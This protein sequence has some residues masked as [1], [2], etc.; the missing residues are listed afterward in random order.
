MQQVKH[1]NIKI[2]KKERKRRRGGKGRGGGGGGKK[3]EK[4]GK[5]GEGKKEKEEGGR[6]ERRG[7]T[8][9]RAGAPPFISKKPLVGSPSL[10]ISAPYVSGFFNINTEVKPNSESGLICV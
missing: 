8:E 4:K 7:E 6:G 2:W 1:K 3:G 9:R 5:K 10:E